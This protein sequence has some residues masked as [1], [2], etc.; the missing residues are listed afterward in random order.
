M[1]DILGQLRE[2]LG[3]GGCLVDANDIAAYTRD[4]LGQQGNEPLCVARPRTTAQ[5]AEVVRCCRAHK[6]AIVPQGGHTGLSGGALP[7]AAGGGIIL[8]LARM[9]AIRAIDSRG[10]TIVA[11]AGVVL[12]DIK[13]AAAEVDRIFPLS[14]GGEGSSQLGGNLSTN[15]GGNNALRYGTARDQ[16]LGLEVVLPSGEVWAGLRTLRKN[17]AGYDLK[18]LFIGSEGTLGIITAAALKIRPAPKVRE[19]MFV[20]LASPDAGLRFLGQLQGHVGELVTAFELLS[21]HAVSA[22]LSLDG[23]R[24][25]FEAP[26]PWCALIE[27][28]SPS[29]RFDLRGAIE[30]AFTEGLESGDVLDAVVAQSGTQRDELWQLRESVAVALI[31]DKSSLKSDTA[32]PVAAV[33]DFI[34]RAET[35][36]GRVVP[37]ARCTPFGHL[38]DGNVHFNVQK[39]DDMA[40]DTFQSHWPA[41]ADAIAEVSLALGGTISAEH[42]IGRTKRRSFADVTAATEWELMKALKATLDHDGLMNPGVLF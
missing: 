30:D 10:N 20:A 2:L 28:D 39:P 34:R 18:H 21:A 29:E 16:V 38:G 8:A 25:P 6:V 24:Y 33:P 1:S 19:T 35:A 31:E 37:G 42:G 4:L 27:A 11:E 32:V 26:H 36:V 22:A 12:A 7:L 17:T 3:P 13:A 9:K 41:L 23:V 14:H 40:G 15:A 5:V